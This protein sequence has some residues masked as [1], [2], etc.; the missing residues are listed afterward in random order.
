MPSQNPC[1]EISLGEGGTC[2]LGEDELR[3]RAALKELLARLSPMMVSRLCSMTHHEL[4]KISDELEYYPE[5]ETR[6]QM[7]GWTQAAQ[8]LYDLLRE[9]DKLNR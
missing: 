6:D 7:A 8:E 3:R 5:G 2:R 9:Q 4:S 1:G